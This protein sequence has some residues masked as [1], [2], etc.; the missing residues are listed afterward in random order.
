MRTITDDLKLIKDEISKSDEFETTV[1]Y[2]NPKQTNLTEESLLRKC[3]KN[4]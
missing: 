4:N 3:S 2:L 1:V